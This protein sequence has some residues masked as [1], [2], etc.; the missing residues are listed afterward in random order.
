MRAEYDH[1]LM[2]ENDTVGWYTEQTGESGKVYL[3]TPD[4]DRAAGDP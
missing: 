4:R 1:L 2:T 3:L